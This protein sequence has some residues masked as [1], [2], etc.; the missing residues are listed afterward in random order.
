M[1]ALNGAGFATAGN[2]SAYVK[3]EPPLLRTVNGR[4]GVM[5]SPVVAV[6]TALKGTAAAAAFAAV[7]A[8]T[9]NPTPAGD[10]MCDTAFCKVGGLAAGKRGANVSAETGSV[11]GT[12]CAVKN[13]W[14]SMAAMLGRDV[15]IGCSACRIKSFA[16]SVV[17]GVVGMT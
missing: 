8:G 17:G 16:S 6:L 3:G 11:S 10:T 7:A 1:L 14:A 15:G 9:A 12:K 4:R 2:S 13:G 5:F